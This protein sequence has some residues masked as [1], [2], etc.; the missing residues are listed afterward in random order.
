MNRLV[1]RK[2]TTTNGTTQP[3]PIPAVGGVQQD[4]RPWPP[5]LLTNHDLWELLQIQGYDDPNEVVKRLVTMG[6][7]PCRFVQE[8]RFTLAEVTRF[9][10]DLTERYEDLKA[11]GEP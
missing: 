2:N 1:R 3:P 10:D 8:R 9:L 7:R 4:A 6:L 11:G 5:P